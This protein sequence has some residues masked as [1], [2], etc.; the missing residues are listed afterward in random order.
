VST[1]MYAPPF[2][3]FFF[4]GFFGLVFFLC[5]LRDGDA[6]R[7]REESRAAAGVALRWACD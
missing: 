7:K 3:C 1:R 5:S 2:A 6:T 4:L